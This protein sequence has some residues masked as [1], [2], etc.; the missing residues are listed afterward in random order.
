M[1]LCWNEGG[2]KIFCVWIFSW[3]FGSVDRLVF[4]YYFEVGKVLCRIKCKG[5][6]YFF[7]CFVIDIDKE[8]FLNLG[9]FCFML[10]VMV[11][12]DFNIFLYRKINGKGNFVC[13]IF[14]EN[15]NVIERVL[16]LKVL[17]WGIDGGGGI[18]WGIGRG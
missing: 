17:K 10:R 6:R 11:F 3:S 1:D 16:S 8:D 18:R 12:W 13:L 15:I 4:F 9:S 5:F 7:W 2:N 14:N